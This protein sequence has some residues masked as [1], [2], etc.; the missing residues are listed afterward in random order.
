[1]KENIGTE[2]LKRKNKGWTLTDALRGINV[3]KKWHEQAIIHNH[4]FYHINHPQ[5]KFR[6]IFDYQLFTL[7]KCYP[8]AKHL[9]PTA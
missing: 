2:S 6:Y 7:L 9:T 4:S 3:T 5:S 8:P 1:M